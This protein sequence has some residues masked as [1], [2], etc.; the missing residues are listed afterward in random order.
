MN[1]RNEDNFILVIKI[2]LAILLIIALCSCSSTQRIEPMERM[3]LEVEDTDETYSGPTQF[4]IDEAMQIDSL[5]RKCER[6]HKTRCIS[7][8]ISSKLLHAAMM[9]YELQKRSI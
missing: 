4:A 8:V 2:I 7:I 6:K 1:P 3:E 5:I 9:A